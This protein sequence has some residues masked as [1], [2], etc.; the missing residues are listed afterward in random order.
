M[1]NEKNGI[2]LWLVSESKPNTFKLNDILNQK[3]N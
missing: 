3:G 1:E 2:S